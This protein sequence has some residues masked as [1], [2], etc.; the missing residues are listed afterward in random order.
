M[1]KNIFTLLFLLLMGVSFT[2]AQNSGLATGPKAKWT[3]TVHDFGK[4][5]QGVPVTT[6]FNFKSIGSAPVIISDVQVS[7]GCTSPNWTKE[8]VLPNKSGKV[9]A[10]Y[11][12]KSI[13]TFNKTIT[14]VTNGNGKYKLTIRGEVVK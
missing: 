1:K 10:K 12:A 9:S 6:T 11:N 3:K 8:A 2:Q 14:V 5:K 13:G 4:I 7:C